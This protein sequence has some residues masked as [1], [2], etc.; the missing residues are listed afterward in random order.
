MSC[1]E[2]DVCTWP[3]EW[4]EEGKRCYPIFNCDR[5]IT[6]GNINC[7]CKIYKDKDSCESNAT[8]GGIF[9]NLSVH[10]CKWKEN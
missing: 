3:L 10:P 7:K 1:V 9:N 4:G 5:S 2:A 6:S 8:S